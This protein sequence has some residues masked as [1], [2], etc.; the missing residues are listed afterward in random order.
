LNAIYSEKKLA[1]DVQYTYST[2]KY[3]ART[4]GHLNHSFVK[5]TKWALPGLSLFEKLHTTH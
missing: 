3:H 2:M 4:H 5:I 1:K